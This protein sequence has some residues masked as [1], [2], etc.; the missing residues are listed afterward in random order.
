MDL[1]DFCGGEDFFNA[2]KIFNTTDPQLSKCFEHTVLDLTPCAYMLIFG[3]IYFLLYRKSYLS[4]INPSPFFKAKMV[5]TVALCLLALANLG[6]GIWEYTHSIRLGYVYLISPAV[7]TIGMAKAAFFLSFDRRKGI[8][9]SIL[10]TFFWLL[11]LVF[12]T[13]IFKSQVERLLDSKPLDD[14]ELFRA[15]TFFISYACVLSLFVMCFFVDDPPAFPPK[16]P[17]TNYNVFIEV[18]AEEHY[19]QEPGALQHG[20]DF[21]HEIKDNLKPCPEPSSSFLSRLTFQW[22]SKI[23]LTGYKCPLVDSD[24]WNLNRV[25]KAEKVV[26]HLLKKWNAEK[27]KFKNQQQER[28]SSSEDLFS[29]STDE[30]VL[31]EQPKKK[32]KMPSLFKA[33]VKTFGPFY[34]VSTVLDLIGVLLT[35]VSPQLLRG[36]ISFTKS[37]AP[38]W[39]GYTLAVLLFLTAMLL[40][41]VQQQ[42]NHAV[43]TVGMRVRSGIIA[44]V[45]RKALTLSNAARKESTV[46][47]IVNLMS[48]DA[49]RM[50]DVTTCIN[51]FWSAPLQI[52]LSMYFLWQTIGPSTLAGRGVMVL[53]V[54]INAFIAS[55]VHKYQ[56][57]QMKH[58]DERI[59]VMNEIL[60]GI[61][62]LKMYAWELSFR[63]KVETIRGKELHVLKRG[64]Y[65]NAAAT[66]TY[67]CAP[68][69]VSLTT[70]GVY[71]LSD[72]NNILDAEKAFVSI[73]LF[74]ILQFPLIILPFS[75]SFL[76]QATVS[77]KRLQKFFCY[78]ELD[79]E[80]V[81]RASCSG[82]L[83]S[84]KNGTFA[85]DKEKEPTLQDINLS[86]PKG[87][88]IA[89]VGQVGSGKSSLINS[90]LG[91]MEKLNGKVS[92]K[93]S[94][95]YVGQQAW[96][97]NLTVRENILFG[98]PLDVCKYQDIIEACELKE[99]FEML[100]ASDQ[101][102]IGEKGI[103]LSGGQKQRV[104]I[105]RAVYQDSDVYLFDDP[106]S[107]VDAHVGKNIFDNV[108][109]PNGYLQKKTRV[110]VTH[111]VSFLPQVDMIVVLV[112]GK[113]SEVGHYD[114]L[115]ERNGDFAE[116]LKNYS[117][118][119]EDEIDDELSAL[120]LSFVG[121]LPDDEDP[122]PII[123]SE[124]SAAFIARR[125]FQR[126][127][128]RQ[129]SGE[130]AVPSPTSKYH[131]IKKDDPN[132]TCK[133]PELK[134]PKA[135]KLIVTETA[136]T[137]NIKASVFLSYIRSVGFVPSFIIIVF[138]ILSSGSSVGSSI[139]LADWTKDS[140]KPGEP[141]DSIA[142]RL[143]IYGV[144]ALTKTIAILV[145]S[146]AFTYGSVA[147]S[148]ALHS[149]ML[150]NVLKATMSFFDTTPLG[151]IV[152]RFSKDMYQID[153]VVPQ[154]MN[155]F[156][157]TFFMTLSTIVVVIY[158]TPIF[159]T[160]VLPIFLL[161]WFVQRFYVRTS[162]QLKRLESIS[163]SPIYS[164]FSETLAGA[165]TIRAYGLQ[166]TFI[167]QNELKVDSN[168]M[169]HYPNIVSNR[170]LALR[171]QIVGNL[172][173][174]F[175][176]I[177]AVV[178]KGH[179]EAAIVGLSISYAMQVT[180][181]L[182][183]MVRTA[184]E[185]ETNIVAV[186]R[187]EEYA[188]VQQEAPLNIEHNLP[189]SSWP[190][191]GGIKFVNYSTRYRDELDL[192]VRGINVDIKGGEKIGVVGRTGAGK[193]SLTLALFRIIE[194]A[195]GMITIDGLDLGK[196]GLHSLRSKLSIIPQDPILFCGTFRMNLDPFDTYSDEK[197]WDALEHSHLKNFV[198][199]LPKKLE[200][201]VAE[202]GENLSVGQ[203]QLVCL[204]RALLRKSKILVLD[205]AT[206]AVDLETDDLIQDTIK[207]EFAD[208][209][210]FTI[211]HRLNT[212]MDSTRV[213][214]LDA[215]KV[216]EFDNPENLLKAKGIF[217]SMAKAAGLAS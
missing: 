64:A 216:A 67:T 61:K 94:V 13:I 102:E 97:Q 92:V 156:I 105:A 178:E 28:G 37:D 146:L 120:N 191:R 79:P 139:W 81:D 70:F 200:H 20:Q 184:S 198:S 132:L 145:S 182:N 185:V 12:W 179:I 56:T 95:A 34:L 112:D 35:F 59:K 43:L 205:E 82:P 109:G 19:C 84:I 190:D 60:N 169:A 117:N 142:F 154:C 204:A 24:L 130:Q 143:V 101:T 127:I 192:V 119:E 201:E 209:T 174:F 66:F 107:A 138:S 36:M 144:F 74:N 93:G 14:R 159:G 135:S 98:K 54:P 121:T 180:N 215:G 73:S 47:E 100:P 30:E 72:P 203:R 170:W 50:L 162:R 3:T 194:A 46:G 5:F 122:E 42:D 167:K 108:F 213:L 134:I 38:A 31:I 40:S 21:E 91:N 168:L 52:I 123:G 160:V 83:I 58:K 22:C 147:A 53:L 1:K 149:K 187:V 44:A 76:V 86:V 65:L 16:D 99:D 27:S 17:S 171:L 90:L 188:S 113:I 89:V 69:L 7:L 172:I 208:S 125:Q 148:T 115:M 111:G 2:D 114:E 163:R 71:T 33:L 62:V 116:F 96:I 150:S 210:T 128:S 202:G 153:Q 133:L 78:D 48:V 32:K 152:N 18:L 186:E 29:T 165:S 55:R 9:S 131:P 103:N 80:N 4:Y 173:V 161:Y 88:L 124:G 217:Y 68:L 10:L 11:Y 155:G 175:A 63:D 197:V 211:A 206:A 25:D 23:I 87:S 176:A 141:H 136:E 104:S 8:R 166:K 106:L 212:I 207:S 41:I 57:E 77:L 129:S 193:S 39:Q 15:I 49:Q 214:V 195:E 110:L 196:M 157:R 51:V 199:T 126:Q 181:T 137:G 177:F 45:Y 6:L 85:W 75:I 26:A 118:Y 151:R 158:S 164:H 140:G 189:N 183:I